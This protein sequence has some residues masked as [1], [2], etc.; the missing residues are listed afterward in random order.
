MGVA[1]EESSA[2]YQMPNESHI[3]ETVIRRLTE[4]DKLNKLEHNMIKAEQAYLADTTNE[5]EIRKRMLK[6]SAKH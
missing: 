6:S 1:D 4:A 5:E 3:L 2:Q